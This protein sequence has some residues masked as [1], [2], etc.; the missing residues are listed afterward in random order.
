MVSLSRVQRPSLSATM[1]SSS[2]MSATTF[3]L[4]S[5][6]SR[7]I[8]S[9]SSP[10]APDLI[11]VHSF[12]RNRHLLLDWPRS[13]GSDAA[14]AMIGASRRMFRIEPWDDPLVAA[15]RWCATEAPILGDDV[16]VSA[17]VAD[18]LAWIEEQGYAA[19]Y[20][21]RLAGRKS[22]GG[23]WRTSPGRAAGFQLPRVVRA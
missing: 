2:K 10:P 15:S 20:A 16:A 8:A 4:L 6:I 3:L 17:C 12:A 1:A 9:S 5:C 14:T 7:L 19:G 18:L 21:L 11:M 22:G 23:L 13:F